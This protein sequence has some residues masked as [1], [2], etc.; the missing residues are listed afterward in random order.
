MNQS[1]KRR[2]H[3]LLAP[4]STRNA[5]IAVAALWFAEF[6]TVPSQAG[7]LTAGLPAAMPNN[8][9]HVGADNPNQAIFLNF[10]S[11]P[12]HDEVFAVGATGGT[13]EYDY[14]TLEP[15]AAT[16]IAAWHVE[17][18]FG[19]GDNFVSAALVFPDLDFD[20]PTP[21]TTPSAG[22]YRRVE[23]FAHLINF[24]D[25]DYGNVRFRLDVPDLPSSVLDFYT[26]EEL[27]DFG[28]LPGEVAFTMRA[29]EGFGVPI[30]EP[31]AQGLITACLAVLAMVDNRVRRSAY[32][33]C[34]V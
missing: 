8:D 4:W 20:G 22:T 12:N 11:A 24:S 3:V 6:A 10:V 14:E 32:H 29:R 2:R 18:G 30:P 28:V 34:H 7:Q 17:L 19:I 25:G 26:P 21:D 33:G 31:S 1:I 16:G 15:N 23:Q 9:D 13:T 27:A 5:I